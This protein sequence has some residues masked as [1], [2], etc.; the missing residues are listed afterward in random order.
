[1]TTERNYLEIVSAI[2]NGTA[3]DEQKQTATEYTTTRL[4]K[5]DEIK[6]NRK[7]S[8]KALA[9]TRADEE[10]TNSLLD[11]M[12]AGTTYAAREV[13]ALATANGI[14]ITTSKIV[15]LLRGCEN[16]TMIDGYKVENK[17]RPVKGFIKAETPTE[18]TAE[19][20]PVEETAEETPT[21]E[22]TAE[23]TTE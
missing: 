15:S 10:L 6:E 20:V 22:E 17:G 5:L 16:I 23:E 18:E 8:E 12:N 11:L 2:L 9:K 4:A 13:L 21:E 19:E 7:T 14:V 3:T 1:M